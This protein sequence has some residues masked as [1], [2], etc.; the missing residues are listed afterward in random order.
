MET[1]TEPPQFND[2]S[3]RAWFPRLDFG[4]LRRIRDA[5]GIDL[6][7]TEQIG[8][9]W[10]T[11]LGDDLQALDVVWLVIEAGANGLAKDDWLSAM[12]G[13][14]LEAALEALRVALV[15]FT[16]PQ[17]RGMIEEAMAKVNQAYKLAIRQ[18]SSRMGEL[19]DEAIAR[20]LARGMPAPASP[21]S[22]DG[23]TIA[24]T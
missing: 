11:L 16:R 9:A 12:D 18:A 21:A 22:L 23:L 2:A 8:R 10:A 19:T 13:D 5:T 17:R 14:R 1:Q 7:N 4:R 15:N 24:G 20:A 3:G 6:G